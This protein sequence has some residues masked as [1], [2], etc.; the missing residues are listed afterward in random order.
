MKQLQESIDAHRTEAESLRADVQDVK[1]RVEDAADEKEQERIVARRRRR[2]RGAIIGSLVI[3]GTA[4]AL[5]ATGTVSG[6]GAVI[7][8][9]AVVVLS[10][11]GAA[12]IVAAR[13]AK[14]IVVVLGIVSAVVTIGALIAAP[15]T[16]DRGSPAKHQGAATTVK[17]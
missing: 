15:T 1:Q 5:I 2:N 7:A 12:R 11:Y 3:D 17:H 4:A 16:G 8:V 9:I 6:T 14:E 13:L 10:L